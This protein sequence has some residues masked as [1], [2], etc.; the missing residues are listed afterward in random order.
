MPKP[1][2]F[3][4]EAELVQRLGDTHTINSAKTFFAQQSPSILAV[5]TTGV[6]GNT[7]RAFRNL[8]VKPIPLHT[9]L[10]SIPAM[11]EKATIR[12]KIRQIERFLRTF[13]RR[14]SCVAATCS[15]EIFA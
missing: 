3:S 10:L 12:L 7:F 15:H 4:T 14:R 8:P 9:S 1:Y 2:E 11:W 6:A 5:V 13:G